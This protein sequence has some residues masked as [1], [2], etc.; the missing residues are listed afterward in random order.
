MANTT[1]HFGRGKSHKLGDDLDEVERIVL[2]QAI[3]ETNLGFWQKLKA[4]HDIKRQQ[5]A[6]MLSNLCHAD[7][8]IVRLCL[9]K[10]AKNDST[11]GKS[12][13]GVGRAFTVA[14]KIQWTTG[15]EI[16]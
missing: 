2:R 11:L 6:K 4:K 9:L 8:E 13:K 16:Q 5:W 12:A 15:K 7:Q 3:E 10:I 1:N 14:T